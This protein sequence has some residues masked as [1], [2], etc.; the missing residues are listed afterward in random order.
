MGGCKRTTSVKDITSPGINIDPSGVA[1]VFTPNGDGKNDVFIPLQGYEAQIE[2]YITNFNI[3]I[4]NR[5]GEKVFESSDYKAEWNGNNTHGKEMPDGV[6]YWIATYQSRCSND[7]PT[8][9]KGFVN[10]LR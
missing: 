7:A 8:T 4:Y 2:Y 3:K 9:T 10:L 6:Y 5:W 1:N